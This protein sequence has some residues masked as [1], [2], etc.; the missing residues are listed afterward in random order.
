MSD[1]YS[2]PR[3]VT[4]ASG[5]PLRPGDP[6]PAQTSGKAT[7]GGIGAA[8]G[9]LLTAVVSGG[10][11]KMTG[12]DLTPELHAKIL[13]VCTAIGSAIGGWVG[14]YYTRNFLK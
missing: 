14:A 7:G 12:A 11:V 13:I 6:V 5:A 1:P 2:D 3:T 9:G 10:L 8:L 4:A